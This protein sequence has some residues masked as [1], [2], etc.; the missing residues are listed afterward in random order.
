[1][2]VGARPVDLMLAEY[3]KK[4]GAPQPRRLPDIFRASVRMVQ[5][6]SRVYLGGEEL[7][8]PTCRYQLHASCFTSRY[9]YI[10]LY[11]YLFSSAG[12]SEDHGVYHTN[13]HLPYC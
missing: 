8:D 2:E 9:I 13:Y 4:T 10:Y 6:D 7:G 11:L 5:Q 1:M 3:Y 12:Y